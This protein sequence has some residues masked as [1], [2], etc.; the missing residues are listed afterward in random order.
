MVYSFDDMTRNRFRILP[1]LAA[2]ILMAVSVFAQQSTEQKP[3]NKMI[4]AP[5]PPV[6][7][8]GATDAAPPSDAIVLFDGRNLEQ[9]VSAQDKSPAKWI[10]KH[11]ILTV[12]KAAGSIETKR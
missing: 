4:F 3:S 11:G 7:T 2:L 9:W 8:P 5:V 10:V 12:N 1:G 6:V